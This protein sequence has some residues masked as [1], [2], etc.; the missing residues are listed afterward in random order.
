MII[1]GK[2]GFLMGLKSLLQQI[3]ADI[4]AGSNGGVIKALHALEETDENLAN[5]LTALEGS[6]QA[7][8]VFLEMPGPP[9]TV[10][11]GQIAETVQK[12]QSARTLVGNFNP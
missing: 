2:L 5:R 9:G 4:L 8:M 11:P 6:I 3:L 10:T 12:I 7:I 1:R